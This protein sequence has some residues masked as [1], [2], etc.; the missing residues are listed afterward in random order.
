MYGS[1]GH[2]RY[3]FES[4]NCNAGCTDPTA[5]NYNPDASIS[6]GSCAYTGCTDSEAVNYDPNAQTDDGLCEY[7][8]SSLGSS[9]FHGSWMIDTS[10]A[11]LCVGEH[12]GD[13]QWWASSSNDVNTRHC[14]YDD[15]YVM[16]PSGSF[17]NILGA[18]T[19]VEATDTTLNMVTYQEC[20]VPISPHDGT[21]CV[22]R[23]HI[24][25][26]TSNNTIVLCFVIISLYILRTTH[27]Y[28]S[29]EYDE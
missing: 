16:D 5:S 6:D 4:Y 3:K 29:L 28:H 10:P 21:L 17:Q 24:P 11:S 19:W 2:W 27:S 15:E 22:F 26:N 7:D 9:F 18:E 25:L 23:N 1:G 12:V 14:L 8:H 13:C 20:T